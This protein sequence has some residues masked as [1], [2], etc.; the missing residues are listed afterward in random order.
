MQAQNDN[1]GFMKNN[2]SNLTFISRLCFVLLLMLGSMSSQAEWYKD[3]QSIMGTL[4]RVELWHDNARKAGQLIDD[5]MKEMHRVDRLMSSYK[6][7]SALSR[8]NRLASKQPVTIN[9]ELFHVINRSLYFS[10]LTSGAFDITYASIGRYYNYR[11]KQYPSDQTINKNINKINYKNIILDKKRLSIQFAIDGVYI[12]LGGIAKGHA[13]DRSF[14]ILKRAG[15]K[16]AIITAGGDSR[17]LGDKRGRPWVLG[18]RDPRKA[19]HI[20]GSLPLSD[21]AL[22]TSGDYERYFVKNGEHFHHILNPSTGKSAK[23]LRSVTIIGPDAI[24]TDA[25]STSIFILG[26]EKGLKLINRMKNIEAVLI[27]QQNKLIFSNG[28]LSKDTKN[29]Q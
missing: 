9:A 23:S 26:K 5:V 19:R 1:L 17:I 22:S 11:K 15:V 24:T 6:K 14:E 29:K 7:N 13:V 4:I 8:I 20:I 3:Q 16:H 21:M 10:R 18:I 12:D 2:A 27:D 25:L 28:L